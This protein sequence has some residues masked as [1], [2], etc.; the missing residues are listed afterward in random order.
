MVPLPLA[1]GRGG[2]GGSL[3]F[4]YNEI[5]RYRSL[6]QG[7]KKKQAAFIASYRSFASH[8]TVKVHAY[9]HKDT[10]ERCF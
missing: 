4:I 1:G 7:S 3:K 8:K 9:S 10:G 5:I 2:Q 6:T